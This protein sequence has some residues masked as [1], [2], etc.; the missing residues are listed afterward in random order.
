VANP[1]YE[2]KPDHGHYAV[3]AGRVNEIY[4]FSR[5]VFVYTAGVSFILLII[6]YCGVP[7]PLISWIPSLFG[8]STCIPYLFAQSAEL[9]LV[10]AVSFF[11]FFR[12]KVFHIVMFIWYVLLVLA[13]FFDHSAIDMITFIIGIVGAVLTHSCFRVYADYNQLI[14]TEGWPHFSLHYAEAMEHPTYTSR[15][16]SE[17]RTAPEDKRIA[18]GSEDVLRSAPVLPEMTG[19][20][21]PEPVMEDIAL[22]ASAAPVPV[23]MAAPEL[24]DGE[25]FEPDAGFSD[26]PFDIQ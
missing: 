22:D 3:C 11:A 17:Y 20:E 6:T 9:I 19:I 21:V 10:T 18:P 14:K 23:T 25:M 5:N 7:M 16:I 13:T 4:E 8:C 2:E 1:K 12:W 15:Y 24:P 26:E